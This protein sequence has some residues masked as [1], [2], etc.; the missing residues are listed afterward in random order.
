MLRWAIASE[1]YFFRSGVFRRVLQSVMHLFIFSLYDGV[2]LTRVTSA[3]VGPAL[4]SRGIRAFC[5]FIGVTTESCGVRK[6]SSVSQQW[7]KN[8][9]TCSFVLIALFL[10]LSALELYKSCGAV[11]VSFLQIGRDWHPGRFRFG[12]LLT[13]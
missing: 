7:S 10:V 12:H 11:A 1:K 5:D 8:L 13:V 4:T 6:F 3:L 2:V 9:E